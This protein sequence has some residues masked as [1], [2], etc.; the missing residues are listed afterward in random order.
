MLENSWMVPRLC[1]YDGLY[2]CASCHWNNSSVV[3]ARIVHNWDFE[4]YCVSRASYQLLRITKSRPLIKL[5]PRLYAFVEELGQ[6]KVLIL[7]YNFFLL[8]KISETCM[9]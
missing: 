2:Y 6:V 8:K 7:K 3:P 1:D 4:Q 5:D 9:I